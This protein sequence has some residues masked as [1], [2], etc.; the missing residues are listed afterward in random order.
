VPKKEYTPEERVVQTKKCK[1]RRSVLRVRKAHQVTKAADRVA[2]EM[3][4]E[5]QTHA[6]AQ[7]KILPSMVESML[8]LKQEAFIGYT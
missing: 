5:M 3:S 7:P 6:K 1:D 4:L 2:T 8:M